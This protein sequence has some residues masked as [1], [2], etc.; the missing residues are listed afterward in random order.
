MDE[1][2]YPPSLMIDNNFQFGW[3]S[4][5]GA[6]STVTL[7][8]QRSHIVSTLSLHWNLIR[9]ARSFT[10]LR[11]IDGVEWVI[12]HHS[13]ALTCST[14]RVDDLNGWS[15]PT[16]YIRFVFDD[17]CNTG[18]SDEDSPFFEMLQVT[19]TGRI[20]DTYGGAYVGNGSNT[21]TTVMFEDSFQNFQNF[22][23]IPILIYSIFLIYQFLLVS[24][25]RR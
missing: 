16:R 14:G 10:V 17:P 5:T 12:V 6:S 25:V 23:Q 19:V 24:I 3:Q 22:C 11:S 13:T 7:D 21:N 9:A 1:A 2:S 20:E 18:S 4:A 15:E 8:T